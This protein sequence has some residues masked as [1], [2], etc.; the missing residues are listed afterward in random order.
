MDLERNLGDQPIALLMEQ[1]SLKPKDLV[2]AAPDQITHKMV[3]R[4]AKGRRLTPNTLAKVVRAM[5][6]A[7]KKEYSADELFNYDPRPPR[8]EDI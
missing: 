8:A 7:A 4:A 3:S 1:H 6:A 5:N 2:A